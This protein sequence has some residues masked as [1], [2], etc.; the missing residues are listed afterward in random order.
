MNRKWIF[1]IAIFVVGAIAILVHFRRYL[2]FIEDDALIPATYAWR[3]LDGQGLTWSDG[4]HVEGYSSL[5][6]LLG[7]ALVAIFQPDVVDAL[8][9]LGIACSLGTVALLAFGFARSSL[10]SLGAAAAGV[11]VFALSGSVAV[12]TAGGLEQPMMGVLVAAASAA[13]LPLL[14]SPPAEPRRFVLP[15]LLFALLCWVRPDAPLLCLPAGI[16]TLLAPGSFADRIRRSAVLAGA[17]ALAVLAQLAFRLVY[18][19]A[20]IPN[21]GLIKVIPSGTHLQSGWTYVSGAW[22]SLAPAALI[23]LASLFLLF[24]RP[25]T[26]AP[27]LYLLLGPLVWS[28]YWLAVGGGIFSGY[29]HFVPVVV[30]LAVG[31]LYGGAGLWSALKPKI[32]SPI[33][34]LAL[35]AVLGG[36]GLSQWN[37]AAYRLASDTRWVWAGRDIS[38]MLRDAFSEED[39]LIAITAAGCMPFWTQMRSL[40]MLGLN[41][42]TIARTAPADLGQGTVGHEHGNGPYVLSREPDLIQ[43]C[44]PWG[45]LEP[46]FRS[47]REMKDSGDLDRDYRPVTFARPPDRWPP[48]I[49]TTVWI[50]IASEKLGTRRGPESTYVPAYLLETEDGTPTVAWVDESRTSVALQPGL[51]LRLEGIP[52]PRGATDWAVLL[53]P[54]LDAVVS[55]TPALD[56]PETHVDISLI[57]RERGLLD[58]IVIGPAE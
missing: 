26:R 23:A 11:A 54:A 5:L 58:A 4:T 25:G 27:A 43:P 6:W 39:P 29:R 9:T 19:D 34:A 51:Q 1:R 7:L 13:L 50:R 52:V 3:L 41:D 8:R 28:V 53:R 14:R 45:G 42:P 16:A 30:L 10:E 31:V 57:S 47:V 18:Y 33:L 56:R 46:C 37:G 2:G 32:P 22:I 40:D 21:T 24:R 36:Y 15:G 35:L 17:P 38:F 44:G 49:K 20:W 55:V 48:H 12:W